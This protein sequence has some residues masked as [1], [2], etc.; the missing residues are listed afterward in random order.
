MGW[1]FF[2]K[3]GASCS[4]YYSYYNVYSH[5]LVNLRSFQFHI[6]ESPPPTNQPTNRTCPP[7]STTPPARASIV[8][9]FLSLHG[10]QTTNTTPLQAENSSKALSLAP[11]PTR[12]GVGDKLVLSA[13]LPLLRVWPPVP[14]RKSCP[15]P[16][17]SDSHHTRGLF[18]I[19]VCTPPPNVKQGPQ[20]TTTTP[21]INMRSTT[22]LC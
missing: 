13:G 17:F 22:I 4:P 9:T 21:S 20:M 1:I 18:V 19:Q 16:M 2:G 11:G 6:Q 8:Y 7:I 12:R 5:P 3:R 15:V 14:C 10:R